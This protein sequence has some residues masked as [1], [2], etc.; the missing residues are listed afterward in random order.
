MVSHTHSPFNPE[1]SII[2]LFYLLLL[3]NSVTSLRYFITVVSPS[4]WSMLFYIYNRFQ[5]SP[6]CI[7]DQH[8]QLQLHNNYCKLYELQGATNAPIVVW[9]LLCSTIVLALDTRL[10]YG[11][12]RSVAPGWQRICLNPVKSE[13]AKE[14]IGDSERTD[15]SKGMWPEFTAQFEDFFPHTSYVV[16]WQI[17]IS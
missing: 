1:G 4:T 8:L 9:Y 13:W 11:I 5:E 14:S 16:T 15:N 10:P 7:F 3:S 6:I 12:L 17:S 2:D